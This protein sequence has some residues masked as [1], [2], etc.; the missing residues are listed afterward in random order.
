MNRINSLVPKLASMAPK[1]VIRR[2]P[3]PGRIME[4]TVWGE[5]SMR[6]M[7]TVTPI[8][9]CVPVCC[10]RLLRNLERLLAIGS[11]CSRLEEE[12]RQAKLKNDTRALGAAGRRRI[13]RRQPVGR[14]AR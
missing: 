2:R 4:N 3:H 5:K 7:I 1:A 9:C 12:F 8:H 14:Q 13:L 10:V 6:Q 11:G